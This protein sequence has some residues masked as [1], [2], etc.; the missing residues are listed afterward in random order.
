MIFNEL[1]DWTIN[2]TGVSIRVIKGGDINNPDDIIAMVDNNPKVRISARIC[3]IHNS[4]PIVTDGEQR[5]LQ[6]KKY[7]GPD[8]WITGSLKT[9][10]HQKNSYGRTWCDSFLSLLGFN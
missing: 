4:I 1:E 2:S 9:V 10:P 7:Q 6:N 5:I 3:N 8:I